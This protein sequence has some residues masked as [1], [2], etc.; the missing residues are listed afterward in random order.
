MSGLSTRRQSGFTLLELMLA[1]AL[2]ALVMTVLILGMNTVV[3][4]WQRTGSR[5]EDKLDTSLGLLQL[6]RALQGAFPH[7]YH[8]S[9]ENRDYLFFEGKKDR[10]TWVSTVSPSRSN[11]LTAWQLQPGKNDEGLELRIAPAYADEPSKRLKKAKAINLLSEYKASF[12][13]LDIDERYQDSDD[14][15]AVWRETWT[16]K[17]AQSL[18]YAVRITLRRGQTEDETL[19]VIGLIAAHEHMTLKPVR[20]EP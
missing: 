6:E 14:D 11:E 2:A 4:D 5:L 10:L 17:K 12:E 8:D 19:E 1:L 13:Y 15:K 3:N 9:K 20:L 18:P 16:A 7:L